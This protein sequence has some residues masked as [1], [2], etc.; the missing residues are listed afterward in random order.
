M[1]CL[2]CR[3]LFPIGFCFTFALLSMI[4][5]GHPALAATPADAASGMPLEAT[6][7]Y[8]RNWP[9]WRG[10]LGTGVAPDAHPPLAWSAKTD[11]SP[12]KNIRWSVALPGA[13]SSTPIVWGDQVF[14]QTAIPTG[15]KAEVVTDP[16]ADAQE[17]S[18]STDKADKAG[19]A[20]SAKA[21]MFNIEKPNEYYQFVLLC[22]DRQTGQERWRKIAAE[23]VPHEGHHPDHGYASYSPV[24]DGTCVISYFGSRGL[25]CYDMHGNLKWEKD[26][27]KMTTIFSFGEGSSP[28]LYGNTVI[29]NWDHEAGSFIIAF[30]KETGEQLWRTER[31]EKSSWATPLVVPTADQTLVVTSGNQTARAYNL[32]D[33]KLVWQCN[34]LTRIAI[35]TPVAANG[36]VYLMSG[37]QGSSLLAIRLG[38]TGDLTGTDA[39]AWKFDKDTPYVPSPLLY[40]GR[41][42]CY[43][44]NKA[45][46]SC[47]DAATGNRLFGP[48]R[49][50][51]MD[52]A[53]ASPVGA[54]GRVYLIG[55]N[56][57]T[58]VIRNADKLEVLATNPLGEGVDASPALVGNELFVRGK[59]H[60]FCIS[61]K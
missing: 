33:G 53:Y 54:D 24:T 25:H 8:V 20:K 26:L 41:L 39:I 17:A 57:T 11:N 28:A 16:P 5:D 42:Y 10:P 47:F 60:L 45:I 61:E 32:A 19:T 46:V 34:G 9:Q 1:R 35:P 59:E 15:R 55:R 22:L 49:L 38:Q 12:E 44:V 43:K 14:I 27:G 6:P 4:A 40:D 29:V 7:E 18:P 30:N 13:G 51:G 36:I 2:I 48:E 58:V 3:V 56:G 31:D 21:P 52:D 50:D 37:F 23:A